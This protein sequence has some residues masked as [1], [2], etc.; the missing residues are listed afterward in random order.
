MVSGSNNNFIEGDLYYRISYPDAGFKYPIIESFVYI[1]KNLSDD[2]EQDTWYF[3]FS[4]D[5]GRHGSVLTNKAGDRKVTLVV[6]DELE[7]MLDIPNLMA[8][9]KSAR[10]RR[11]I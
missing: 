7:E 3:Q 9:L 11:N 1:G 4:D 10:E 8:E 2:N 6:F 5:Y